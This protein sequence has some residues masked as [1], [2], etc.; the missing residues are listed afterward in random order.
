M[1]RKNLI[2]ILIIIGL[3]VALISVS[4]CNSTSKLKEEIRELTKQNKQLEKEVKESLKIARDA[5][6]NAVKYEIALSADTAR[7][8]QLG[9]QISSIKKDISII[10]YNT[11]EK[12]NS[13]INLSDS[14]TLRLF[15]SNIERLR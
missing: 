9:A 15:Y 13:V 1:D 3:I 4:T 6:A 10:K 14:A 12:V 5:Q 8:M 7:L 2:Y 11:N